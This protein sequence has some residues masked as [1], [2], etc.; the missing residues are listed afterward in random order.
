MLKRG[1]ATRITN[2]RVDQIY[3]AA[4]AAGAGGGKLLGAGGGGFPA[5]IMRSE[6]RAAVSN[7]L[8]GLIQI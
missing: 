8:R 3:Q 7:A 1:L 4:M 5:F 2:D 6:R